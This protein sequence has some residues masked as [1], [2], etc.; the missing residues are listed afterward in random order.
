MART[1]RTVPAYA[2]QANAFYKT[3]DGYDGTRDRIARGFDRHNNPMRDPEE[4]A[5]GEVWGAG[6]PRAKRRFS[7]IRR[8]NDVKTVRQ[9][10]AHV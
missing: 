7:R 5:Y 6:K 9:E 10:L 1:K 4:G 3:V 2:R 8:L